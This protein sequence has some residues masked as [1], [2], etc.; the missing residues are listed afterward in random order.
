V[1]VTELRWDG[2]YRDGKRVAPVRIEL[3]FQT[4]ETVNESAQDRAR[5]LDLF[6]TG[7][8][9]DWR[10][11][12]IWGDKKYVLPSLRSEF[13]GTV[14]LIYIDPPFETGA[15]FSIK[16]SVPDTEESLSK[17]PSSIEMKAYRDTWGVSQQEKARGVTTV[18]KYLRW[19]AD[20][21]ALLRDLLSP[22]GLLF[23]HLD[24]NIGHEAK[25]VLDEVFGAD[26][27]QGEIIWQLGTGAK[28]RKF[29]SIQHNIILAYSGGE[30][31]TF[32]HS[33]K[34]ARE[35]FAEGSLGT[36][37]RRVDEDG[38]RYRIK[39]VNGKDY[40]Y[41]ADEGRLIGSVWTDISSMAANSP[42]IAETTGYPTQK[43]EKLLERIISVCSKPNDLVLDCFCGSGTTAAVAEKLGRRWIACD[44]SRFAIH[45]TRKRL[46]SIP[47][48]KP[49]LVQNLGK[50]E[51]GAW[52]DTEFP[53][54]HEPRE[55]AYRRFILELFRAEPLTGHVWIHGVKAG[56]YVHVG[57]IDAPVT[58]SD[59]KAISRDV[60]RISGGVN[61]RGAVDI[62]AWEFAFELN[63]TAKQI[64]AEAN[65]EVQFRR[66]PRDVL[67]RRA[68]EQGDVQEKD[69]FELRVFSTKNIIDNRNLSV[70]L[71]DFM[72][73]AEDLPEDVNE[74]VSH[75]SQWID[76]WAIDWDY[77]DDTF[78]NQWQSYRTREAV[79][80]ELK[81][82][83]EYAAPGDYVV[84]VKVIDLLGCDTTTMTHV[85]VL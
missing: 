41:Y 14:D 54:S 83:H 8:R 49:F 25:V 63:A 15:D 46:L 79:K 85:K 61:C 12:L 29:F 24:D 71:T 47:Q 64:A 6:A 13:A 52:A 20:T 34:I 80:L 5:T 48:V 77:R 2:K 19:F 72:M 17:Q 22:T 44:L 65:V 56:R 33:E 55:A 78:H 4:V 26:R 51:R 1:I 21:A 70:E 30:Q 10:N 67:D 69:F 58:A 37:F 36:H 9:T 35:P 42:I 62:L 53:G 32:N 3:P 23:V 7:K 81:A 57:A 66:I 28:S 50:Y 60:L 11:R 38:R 73:P 68:V 16:T 18:D 76:Y 82:R 59:V 84:V 39:T 74:A 31:W 27:F 43:P 75:W 40:T 45:T